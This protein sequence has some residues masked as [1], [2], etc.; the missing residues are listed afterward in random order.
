MKSIRAFLIIPAL[1]VVLPAQETPAKMT[2]AQAEAFARQAITV[3]DIAGQKA[4]L[5]RLRAHRF[6]T[7]KIKEREFVLYA[8]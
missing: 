5:E 1:V 7:S 6:R 3:S 2:D 8:Q 4:A